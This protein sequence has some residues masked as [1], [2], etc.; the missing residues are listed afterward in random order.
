MRISFSYESLFVPWLL[1]LIACTLHGITHGKYFNMIEDTTGIMSC[2]SH[3]K[4]L[5]G[6]VPGTWQLL[7]V[8]SVFYSCFSAPACSD[9]PRKMQ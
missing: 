1:K 9:F 8:R 5:I 6:M 4:W 3:L 7:Q 2:F